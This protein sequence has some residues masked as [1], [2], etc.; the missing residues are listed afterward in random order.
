M[1]KYI[2]AMFRH[3]QPE[4]FYKGV[5]YLAGELPAAAT[6]DGAP[7]RVHIVLMDEWGTRI[8][9]R[10]TSKSDGTWVFRWLDP[11]R[12]YTLLAFDPASNFNAAVQY[13]VTPYVTE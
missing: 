2:Y 4:L 9:N 1:N 8:I 11:N 13:G 10:T 12:K 3:A 6:I 7:A 5:G